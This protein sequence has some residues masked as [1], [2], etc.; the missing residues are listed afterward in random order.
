MSLKNILRATGLSLLIL[1][2]CSFLYQGTQRS[3]TATVQDYFLQWGAEKPNHYI[4][5]L[6]SV[7]VKQGYELITKGQTTRANG[8]M[9]D[10]ISGH[11][12]CTHCH[13]I[14]K[15]VQ[16]FS[17]YSTTKRA[18]Y[19]MQN[20]IPY[21]PGSS[22]YGV[23]NR[24]TW[25][26]DDYIKKY[27]QLVTNARDTLTNAIQLCA[28]ECSQGRYLEDWELDVMLHYL[29]TLE[30]KVA[31]VGLTPDAIAAQSGSSAQKIEWMKS[32]YPTKSP[33]TFLE[34]KYEGR[35]MGKE[36]DPEVGKMIYEQGCQHCHT[37]DHGP[38]MFELDNSVHTFKYLKKRFDENTT[39][40]IYYITRK[41]TYPKA[42]Y[43]P[44]M[45]H[46]TEE[47]MSK[48]QLES[49]AAYIAQK[50]GE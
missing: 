19:A 49:L 37:P 24:E 29:W 13:T 33:A 16:D 11:F 6:D 21:L 32:K 34:P 10:R 41:G 50:A 39:K 31:D 40:S 1:V 15:E 4:G 45:P 35:G 12:N 23:V 46:Y 36:G 43:K 25:Y 3:A 20:T 26:N 22:L 30:L 2:F 28:K 48:T 9:S 18:E 47:R 7:K 42:Y 17:R 38:A 8:K 44:Y 27:G 5:E 14:Q